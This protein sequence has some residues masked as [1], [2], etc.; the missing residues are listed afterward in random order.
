MRAPRVVVFPRPANGSAKPFQTDLAFSL[1]RSGKRR[2]MALALFTL[3]LGTALYTSRLDGT[4][5]QSGNEAMYALASFQ[6]RQTAG[7]RAG[8]VS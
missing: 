1:I 5:I 2:A 4:P 6:S 7:Q 8:M 3:A